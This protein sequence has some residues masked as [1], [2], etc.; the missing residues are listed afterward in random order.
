MHR[1]SLSLFK[2]SPSSQS[3]A[4][5]G[6]RRSSMM[7]EN[8]ATVSYVQ[9]PGPI[10]P[11]QR[12]PSSQSS[13]STGSTASSGRDYAEMLDDDDMAWSKPKKSKSSRR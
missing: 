8:S 4:H 3:S 2:S 7:S 13:Q 1:P 12:Q 5:S 11:A 9:F 6:S 10:I